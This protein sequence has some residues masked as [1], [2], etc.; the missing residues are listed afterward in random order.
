VPSYTVA[1]RKST[2]TRIRWALSVLRAL[3]LM[4][5]L[6]RAPRSRDDVPL[7]SRFVDLYPQARR[8]R[9]PEAAVDQLQVVHQ[10]VR[11]EWIVGGIELQERRVGAWQPGRIGE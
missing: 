10:L 3:R 9:N 1:P 2:S 11:H 8:G 7:Q 6:A 5:L 4:W